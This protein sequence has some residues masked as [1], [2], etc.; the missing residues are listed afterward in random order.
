MGEYSSAKTGVEDI[1]G[2]YPIQDKRAFYGYYT[3]GETF[4]HKVVTEN[5]QKKTPHTANSKLFRTKF[6]RALQNI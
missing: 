2:Y 6:S 3:R 1:R 5:N 4:V